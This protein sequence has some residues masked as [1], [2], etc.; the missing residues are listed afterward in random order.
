[1]TKGQKIGIGVAITAVFIAGITFLFRY[2]N[3]GVYAPYKCNE[4]GDSSRK[5]Y[6][7]NWQARG[8]VCDGYWIPFG[9][10]LNGKSFPNVLGKMV[11]SP[12]PT[13]KEG[14]KALAELSATQI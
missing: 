2:M 13:T 5:F 8:A 12:K 14:M 4:G 10:K 11:Q 6:D 3:P 7:P 9:S 1:M